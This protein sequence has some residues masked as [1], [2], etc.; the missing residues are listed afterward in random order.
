M[1]GLPIKSSPASKQRKPILPNHSPRKPQRSSALGGGGGGGGGGWR[2]IFT[3]RRVMT[4]L[5]A[6]G[7][8]ACFTS[9]LCL[10]RL[11]YRVDAPMDPSQLLDAAAAAGTTGG[12]SSSADLLLENAARQQLPS[13]S[14]RALH[15]LQQARSLAMVT[16]FGEHQ[17][18]QDKPVPPCIHV[19]TD[20]LPAA[21]YLLPRDRAILLRPRPGSS[22]P[23]AASS[24]SASAA[25]RQ[26]PRSQRIRTASPVRIPPAQLLPSSSPP[27]PAFAEDDPQPFAL[28]WRGAHGQVCRRWATDVRARIREAGRSGAV[29]VSVQ[30]QLG[31]GVGAGEAGE[32]VL[33]VGAVGQSITR[34]REVGPLV[35]L[36]PPS[37]WYLSIDLCAPQSFPLLGDV[38]P[39]G[40][41]ATA[42]T[43]AAGTGAATD[44]SGGAAAAA[45]AAAGVA[46]GNGSHVAEAVGGVGVKLSLMYLTDSS[47]LSQRP[48]AVPSSRDQGNESSPLDATAAAA[49]AGAT[50]ASTPVL[51]TCLIRAGPRLFYTAREPQGEER[52]EIW[53]NISVPLA[54]SH[55]FAS[56]TSSSSSPSTASGQGHAFGVAQLSVQ[57]D[58]NCN[59]VQHT[60]VMCRV[61][62]KHRVMEAGAASP[63]C[64]ILEDA[65]SATQGLHKQQQQQDKQQQP[66]QQQQHVP[67]RAGWGSEP[68]GRRAAGFVSASAAADAAAAAG[69]GGTVGSA[70]VAAGGGRGGKG[71]SSSHWVHT[72]LLPAALPTGHYNYRVLSG[73]HCSPVFSFHFLGPTP[74]AALAAHRSA[75]LSN[76]TA[77]PHLSW[78]E[79]HN[80]RRHYLK[81]RAAMLRRSAG[82]K[83]SGGGGS[84]KF[85]SRVGK[86]G[87]WGRKAHER[88]PVSFGL[89]K[90][91]ESGG[92]G[93]G[94]GAGT[95]DGTGAGAGVGGTGGDLAAGGAGAGAGAGADGAAAGAGAG[96]A[97]AEED[98]GEGYEDDNNVDDEFFHLAIIS[99]TQGGS[100]VF[101]RHLTHIRAHKPSADLIMHLGDRV[102]GA[103]AASAAVA[104]ARAAGGASG[105]SSGGEADA[106]LQW[107]R[108]WTQPLEASHVAASIPSLGVHGDLDVAVGHASGLRAGAGTHRGG[109]MGGHTSSRSSSSGGSSAT[110]SENLDDAL[111]DAHQLADLFA[112]LPSS[113]ALLSPTSSP[114]SPPSLWTVPS[115]ATPTPHPT[116]THPSTMLT[117]SDVRWWSML[118]GECLWIGLDSNVNTSSAAVQTAWLRATLEA[119]AAARERR[120]AP[121]FL[122]VLLHVPP[123]IDYWDPVSWHGS[124]S[125][126]GGGGLGGRGVGAGSGFGGSGDG[127]G[128]GE[129]WV[130]GGGERRRTEWVRL[131][132]VPLFE[133]YHVDLVVS[134][135]SHAYQRGERNGVMYAILGGGGE[136]IDKQRVADWGM[137]KVT[138]LG[139]HYVRVDLSAHLL[140]WTAYDA[141]NNPIDHVLFV[142]D[143]DDADEEEGSQT[144]R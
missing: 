53:G 125:G 106:V 48:P 79:R 4:V 11:L 129:D 86:K 78:F 18:Q 49:A 77:G 23:D 34:Q 143:V 10:M 123:F 38:P 112:P 76:R 15:V 29:Y 103:A 2:G 139:H 46:A 100:S 133:K 115:P 14:I 36:V 8:L 131:E 31:E 63:A 9:V 44:S 81:T 83:D 20:L 141:A 84:P 1:R 13:L 47:L 98:E 92:A 57:W 41:A 144:L 107:E 99:D 60:V 71:V 26:F 138:H 54:S 62:Q 85:E 21:T 6:G 7:G 51:P 82:M 42:G 39:P 134:G 67:P 73:S 95:G 124:N 137:Y 117:S 35:A 121:P 55:S 91:G 37:A 56:S 108:M 111:I 24:T 61:R 87:M 58:S 30:L 114:S 3:M 17:P 90:A 109:G 43:L 69:G 126:G 140:S 142:P 68:L 116:T 93:A 130:G 96:G 110:S 64:A 127:E 19:D 59:V 105:G 16:G 12:G 122:A 45:A 66:Q 75:A 50:A 104:A 94:T 113:S 97:A 33:R 132:W 135:H 70:T 89:G 120:T 32:E 80:K 101:R 72:A 52:E 118:L 119:V 25:T 27:S 102:P 5:L 22:T 40:G 65:C 136:R 74:Y 128:S 28:V 88:A